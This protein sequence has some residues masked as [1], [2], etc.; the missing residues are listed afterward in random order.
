MKQPMKYPALILTALALLALP[1]C[2]QPQA[3]YVR[4]DG[5]VRKGTAEQITRWVQADLEAEQAELRAA[6]RAFRT[7]VT[8]TTNRSAEAIAE[9]QAAYDAT[10]DDV[11]AAVSRVKA[12]RDSA[13]EAIELEIA[14]R[15]GVLAFAEQA[16]PMVPGSA[17]FSS[18]ILGGLAA[19]LGVS[20]LGEKRRQDQTWDEAKKEA[21]AEQAKR[22][23][24]YEE[25]FAKALL[26]AS[27]PPAATL[28]GAAQ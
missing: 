2:Q 13:L 12:A 15:A 28:N 23:A 24:L 5:S 16:L 1:G 11:A 20:K 4:E 9:L 10:A 21:E 7:E 6:E 18:L 19:A 17:P 26:L 3:E 22:D 14:N 25:A 27:K 8:K